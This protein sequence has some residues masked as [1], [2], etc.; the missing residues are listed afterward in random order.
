M[1][2]AS[3]LIG[4]SLPAEPGDPPV[5]EFPVGVFLDP[6]PEGPVSVYPRMGG[7]GLLPP[8]GRWIIG[9]WNISSKEKAKFRLK[10][11]PCPN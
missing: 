6:G 3:S 5:E 8:G 10:S 1:G 9:R 4:A 2:F 11:P 7:C